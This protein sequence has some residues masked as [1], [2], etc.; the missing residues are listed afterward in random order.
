MTTKQGGF[1]VEYLTEFVGRDAD[2][3]ELRSLIATRRLVTIT[4]QA[5]I[6]KSRVAARLAELARRSFGG[7]IVL[8]EMGG[9][10]PD[11]IADALA[12]ALGSTATSVDG[13]ARALGDKPRLVVVDDLH[14]AS[15]AAPLLEHLLLRCAETRVLVTSRE[16][17]GVR[18]E[19]P[20]VLPPLEL[21]PS[22][23]RQGS[24]DA[25]LES[26]AGSMLLRLI[27][28]ADPT[29]QTNPAT[30]EDLLTVCTVTDGVP[31]FIEAA[32]RAVCVLGP[33]AAALAVSESPEVLD[34]FIPA[35][36][37]SVTARAAFEEALAELSEPTRQLL[38]RIALFTSG[39]DLRFA[40]EVFAA[41][42]VAGIAAATAELVEHSL[43]RS[44]T[45]GEERRLTVPLHYRAPSLCLWD[46]LELAAERAHVQAG[47]QGRLRRCAASWFSEGQLDSIQF[48]NRHAADVT[49]LL[50]AMSSSPP[51]AHEALELISALRY[52]WQLHPVDPWP[53]ARD[54]LGT[55]L[56]IDPTRDA[57]TLRA[58][59]TDAY[60]A[61]HEGDLHDAR[62]QL[63]ASHEEFDASLTNEEK[64]FALFLEA[65][66]ELAEE[67]PAAAV[68]KLE[69]V[70]RQ[71]LQ[72]DD[73]EHLGEKYWYLA[74]CQIAIGRE[75]DAATTLSQGLDYCERVG[76]VWG[77]AYM[78][79]LMAVI[80][81]RKD[82]GSEAVARIRAAVDIMSQ[83]G[84]R[85]GLA[86]CVRLLASV[87]ARSG[88]DENVV[89][90]AALVP[91]AFHTGPP[92]P[93]PELANTSLLVAGPPA[94]LPDHQ[95]L[96]E[97]LTRIIDGETPAV[98]EQ[99]APTS[100]P[101][102]ARE[103]EIA[104]LVAE[105]LGNPAIA[106]R[107]VLSRRTVE[108]HVQRILA[109]LGFR[110]RS[111]IAVWAAQRSAGVGAR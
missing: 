109:K 92:V 70:L 84:D 89:R 81:D 96:G 50:G 49:A 11:T 3:T 4:G 65:L 76:D 52:Y 44:D 93:L 9:R 56:A 7:S 36:A 13:L 94:S 88:S 71:C 14:L 77:R 35:A 106:A 80:A 99:R 24:V 102:S 25:S 33:R 103:W 47:L 62:A 75:E 58:M 68:T 83:Y 41:G 74:M 22:G 45:V 5:G 61:F 19:V 91:R 78:W 85:A 39:C 67:K 2:L 57:I 53:R 21:P 86:L 34:A 54:W 12:G 30:V 18:G 110:T 97:V 10:D 108:G 95:S 43:V 73:R 42:S 27:R 100:D 40:A 101:L 32:A 23:S 38:Q 28:D 17:L 55:A 29:L 111:Q 59:Q 60:I 63:M 37:R 51:D 79:W 1:P 8:V 87:S 46:P 72:T 20:Y 66:I 64:T 6:G 31:R 98:V 48:L 105:G 26:P 107:L 69:A 16:R 104:E 90:L 82:R 15:R